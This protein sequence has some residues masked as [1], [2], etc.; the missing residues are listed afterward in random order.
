MSYARLLIDTM[1]MG[2]LDANDGYSACG[3]DAALLEP[4]G[5]IVPNLTEKTA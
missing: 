4:P 2:P 1:E 3:Q 5:I